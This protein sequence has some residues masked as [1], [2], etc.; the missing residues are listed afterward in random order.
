MNIWEIEQITYQAI[1]DMLAGQGAAEY[2]AL[3]ARVRAL[4]AQKG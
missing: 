1:R 4:D 2:I 3:E